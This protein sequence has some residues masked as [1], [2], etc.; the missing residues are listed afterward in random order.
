MIPK[1]IATAVLVIVIL[2]PA[3][4]LPPKPN[5]NPPIPTTKMTDATIIFLVTLKSTFSF[6]IILTPLEAINPYKIN[7]TPPVIQAGTVCNN[8]VNGAK[9]PN[10]IENTDA[11]MITETDAILETP[12]TATFSPYV[13]FAAPQITPE[14]AV[15]TPSP[16][17]VLVKPGSPSNKSLSMRLPKFL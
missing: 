8:I 2:Y 10:A 1:T 9:N 4:E 12:I 17:N 15:A 11:R 14:T 13:V 3:S 7:E 6:I 5:T 16:I